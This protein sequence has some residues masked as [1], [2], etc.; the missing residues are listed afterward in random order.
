M[1]SRLKVLLLVLILVVW[2]WRSGKGSQP[3]QK[4][5]GHLDNLCEI[6]KD[7]VKTPDRGV[8]RWFGYMGKHTPDMMKQLGAT[9]VAIE[10]VKDDDAHD[11]RARKAADR[12]HANLRKCEHHYERFFE[13]VESDPAASQRFARGMMR[14]GRT[15]EILLGMD[16]AVFPAPLRSRIRRAKRLAR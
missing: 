9:F 12:L 1:D 13:A 14:L 11:R 10:R 8:E 4:L 6:A 5:V 15:L 2:W 16:E 3:D 7:N